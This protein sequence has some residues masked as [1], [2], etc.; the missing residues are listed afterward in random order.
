[1]LGSDQDIAHEWM[2]PK[3]KDTGRAIMDFFIKPD[4]V[5]FPSLIIMTGTSDD[6]RELIWEMKSWVQ[7]GRGNVKKVVLMIW[8]MHDEH[9]ISGEISVYSFKRGEEKTQYRDPLR[10]VCKVFWLKFIY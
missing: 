4:G 2:V 8:S 6:E 1:M 10:W 9:R 7:K 5:K 3:D